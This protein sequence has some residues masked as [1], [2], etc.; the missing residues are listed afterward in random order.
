MT[1]SYFTFHVHLA[2]LFIFSIWNI[3]GELTSGLA[4]P[5]GQEIPWKNM[6]I[7]YLKYIKLGLHDNLL[8]F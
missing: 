5:K 3:N 7:N 8:Q 2:R 6:A 4:N 1:T